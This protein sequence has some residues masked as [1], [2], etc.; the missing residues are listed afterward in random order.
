V[1]AVSGSR[2]TIEATAEDPMVRLAAAAFAVD[3]KPWVNVF[4]CDGLFDR[5]TAKFRFTVENLEPGAHVLV[6]RVRDAAGNTGAGDA[7]LTNAK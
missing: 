6:L 7:M 3:G 2:A 4:P 1:V 5:K